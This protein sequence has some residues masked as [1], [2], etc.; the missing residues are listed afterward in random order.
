MFFEQHDRLHDEQR[1]RDHGDHAKAR[2]LSG[3]QPLDSRCSGDE[4]RPGDDTRQA[5]TYQTRQRVAGDD[6]A[7][8]NR[9][10]RQN[11]R[12]AGREVRRR[13]RV[14]ETAT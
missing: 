6:H 9:R 2:R 10:Q 12:K 1:E 8:Q 13:Q 4:N 3:T 7:A 5:R 11:D 14:H